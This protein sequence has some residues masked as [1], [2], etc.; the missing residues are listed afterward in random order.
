MARHR[1][2]SRRVRS[3]DALGNRLRTGAS[4]ATESFAAR[5]R[6][7]AGH[8]VATMRAAAYP[9]G[10]ALL[11]SSLVDVPTMIGWLRPVILWP[12]ALLAGLSVEQFEAL[13]PTNWLT[14][15]GTTI[16]ST[17]SKRR[18]RRCS[19]TSG[20][21]V[22][23][24]RIRHERELRRSG[25]CGNRLSYARAL[26]TLEE[27]RPPPVNLSSPPTAAASSPASAASSASRRRNG[28]KSSL[29][30][31]PDAVRGNAH[32]RRRSWPREFRDR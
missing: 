25:K 28:D 9:L 22:A 30:P 16:S 6:I 32:S 31:R 20:R 13:W 12:P 18:S 10:S 15:G 26:A 3:V 4:T 24:R 14:C 23:S 27:L 19:S 11:E 7:M 21:L 2:A 8:L 17:L 1:L 29:A 5:R